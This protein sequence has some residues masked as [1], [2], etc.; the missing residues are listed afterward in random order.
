[1]KDME[2][3]FRAIQEFYK[4]NHDFIKDLIAGGGLLAIITT[5]V[6]FI[7]WLWWR[8]RQLSIPAKTFAFEVIKPQS[9]DLKQR[10]FGGKEDDPLADENISYQARV[11]NRNI[12]RELQ[13]QIEE[14]R[15]VLIVG[16]TGLGKTREAVELA[17]RFN[18]LG[19]TTLH[20]KPGKWLDIPAQM[21]PEIGT[22]RK[23]LF[24]LDDLNQKMHRGRKEIAPEAQ[25]RLVEKFN[26]P[27]QERL[28]DALERYE[29]FCGQA[30]VRVIATARNER[31]SQ[32][33]GEPSPWEQLQWQKYPKLWQRFTVYELPPPDDDAIIGML[34]ETIPNTKI[35]F[36]VEQYPELAKRNDATFRNV[37]EN[38]RRLRAD[39]L[40]LNPN[41][42]RPSLGKTWE[43]RYQEALRRYPASRYIYDAVDLLIQFDISLEN[44]II[45]PTALLMVRGNFWQQLRCRFFRISSAL[46]YLL[47]VERIGN[48]RDGQIEAKGRQVEAGE[49]LNPLFDLVLQLTDR[50]SQRMLSSLR[51][52]GLRLY[53]LNRYKKA[54]IC[55]NRLTSLIPQEVEFWLYRGA[56]L[57]NLG[58]HEEEIASYD[59]ALEFKPDKDEAWY[60]RGNALDNLGRYEEAVASYDKAL[61]F[62]PDDDSGWYNRGIALGNLGR[63]EETVA[64]YDKALE[65][66][67]D[68][69]SAWY[70]R[71]IALDNL[72]RYEEAVASYDKALEFK[73][74][75]DSA[76]YNRG[77]ALDNLGRY[78]EAVASYDKALE[79]KPD[80]DEAWNNRGIALGN[81]ERYEEA[82]AS[83]DKALEFKPDYDSAWYNRG[84]APGEFGT[85]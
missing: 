30:E 47:E 64:S 50:Y 72:G 44:F 82:V 4:S 9:K 11:P 15:W 32:F 2:A 14:H 31:Q 78:E 20:L 21:P 1:M 61:E 46:D 3:V 34:A 42:Y 54:Y 43:K 35:K 41:T 26:V 52:F 84:I 10:I 62:K 71:G 77:I 25:E 67:P 51:S 69:D 80:K 65:F 66:K 74:D 22:D 75:Y 45:K 49:Y 37:V 55:F 6:G 12:R 18:Q 16:R 85:L 19:W 57:G 7:G 83:Y 79:F 40:P 13:E 24:F 63:Y 5:V 23:L 28:S 8:Q 73:P 36:K 58:R 76:W 39:D 59:K 70:N 27:L 81:L 29:D 60:N 48:P 53:D 38:L 68:Y 33:E 17:E 56:A